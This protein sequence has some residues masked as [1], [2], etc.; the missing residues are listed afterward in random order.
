MLRIVP[1]EHRSLD[2]RSASDDHWLE[3]PHHIHDALRRPKYFSVTYFG[4]QLV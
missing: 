2:F 3:E 1:H 4:M